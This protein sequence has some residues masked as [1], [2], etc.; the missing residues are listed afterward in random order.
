MATDQTQVSQDDQ[1]EKTKQQIR[2]LVGEIAQLSKSDMAPEEYYAAFLQ[3]VIQALAAVGGAVWI[4]GEG[5]R[6]QLSYQVKLSP[7]LLEKD[8]EEG[9]KHFR[10]LDYVIGSGQPA[11]IPPMSGAGDEKM[12]GNPTQQLLVIAPLGHDGSVEGLVEIFQRPD[13]QPNTQRG[14]LRF[15]LQMCELAGEWFKN[16]KLRTFSDKSSLWAQADQFSRAVHESLVLRET[17]Y[18]VVN[19]GRRLMGCD[20]VTVAIK[21]GAKCYVE[22]VS[23]QDTLDNRSN[24]VTLLGTLATRVCASGEPLWYLGSTDDFPPQIENAIEEYVD[25]SYTKSL[26]VIPLRKPQSSVQAP[27]SGP[28]TE[29][30]ANSGEIVGALIVEQIESEIP[31]EI[32]MPRLDLVYEHSARAI[33]NSLDHSNLFLMPIWRAIGKSAFIVQART[34]PKT[35]TITGAVLLLLILSIAIPWNFDMYAK[36]TLQP[37]KKQDVFAP[38]DA[39]V[40]KVNFDNGDHV[41]EGEVL[42][43]LESDQLKQQL[44]EASGDLSK[45][46]KQLDAARDLLNRAER[47]DK[48]SEIERSRAQTDFD[49]Q[50]V[51]V[52]NLAERIKILQDREAKLEIKAPMAGR[53]ITWD[54]KKLLDKRP[55]GVG[56][57]LMTLAA[58][59][60]E[61]EAELYMPERRVKHVVDYRKKIQS[62]DS[63][64]ELSVSYILMTDPGISHA[65]EVVDIHGGADPSEEHGNMIRIRV[66]PLDA[67]E[68]PRPGATVTGRVHCGRAPLLWCKL[69]EAWEFWDGFWFG[70]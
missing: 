3:R 19:E 21:K 53:I 40:L 52:K 66:K 9:Q 38:E 49:T 7:E 24:V 27:A 63:G 25:Q 42:A 5:K 41:R 43:V 14:Y 59:D 56:Q 64:K 20:R 47:S 15:L 18:T 10:L 28:Q 45:A 35:L 51:V 60:T 44:N 39:R 65:G 48:V 4:L 33:T 46:T 32:L 61:Y 2:G 57:V 54:V 34:L 68:N 69:H 30:A 70:L 29:I 50:K 1:I 55:V 22:A 36:G 37:V 8:S 13:A 58:D 17:C 67:L 62:K 26:A 11:L 12:G 23:G 31:R 6:P 16:R